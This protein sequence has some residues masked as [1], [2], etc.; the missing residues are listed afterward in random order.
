MKTILKFWHCPKLSN[1]HSW[2]LLIYK[3]TK[4][5]NLQYIQN[6]L[7]KKSTKIQKISK[8]YYLKKVQKLKRYEILK[9]IKKLSIK[10]EKKVWVF[11]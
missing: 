11:K 6:L 9:I 8:I 5:K 4:L 1:F 3:F 2:N 7:I 10:I